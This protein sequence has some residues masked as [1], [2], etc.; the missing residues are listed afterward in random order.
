[1]LYLGVFCG[2]FVAVSLWSFWLVI[3]P[4]QIR[5][6][7]TPDDFRLP[8]KDV[9]LTASDGVSLAAWFIPEKN[10]GAGKRAIIFLHGYP[11]DKSDMLDMAAG[12]HHEYGLLLMDLRS[13]GDSGGGYT[14]LGIRERDDVKK[15]LDFLQARGYERIGIFGFSLGGA[16]AMLAAADDSRISALVTYGALADFRRL[17]YETYDK[18]LFLKYPLVYFME[19]WAR[20]LFGAWLSDHA[21]AL[22]AQNLQIP[23][24]LAHSREDEQISFSHFERLRGELAQNPRAEF[25][26]IER[27]IHGELPP[28]F[29]DRVRIFWEQELQT[30]PSS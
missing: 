3:Q 9:M 15:A 13:F 16:I 20:L 12:L 23:L 14:T 7:R 6:G 24:L 5:T 22:A 27:G 4:Q 28:E 18:L 21:P 29:N 17:G 2:G 1:M 26:I 19:L 30:V 11:A 8:A 25:F 10:N